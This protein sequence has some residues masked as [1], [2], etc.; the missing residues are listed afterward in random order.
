[1]WPGR[2]S[3]VQSRVWTVGQS[4]GVAFPLRPLILSAWQLG[5]SRSRLPQWPSARPRPHT[6]GTRCMSKLPSHSISLS[7]T[8]KQLIGLFGMYLLRCVTPASGVHLEVYSGNTDFDWLLSGSNVKSRA[9]WCLLKVLQ[10]TLLLS[11]GVLA[12]ALPRTPAPQGCGPGWSPRHGPERLP[13]PERT[14]HR[15]S[16]HHLPKPAARAAFGGFKV[17]M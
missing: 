13:R 8:K 9:P 11:L 6:R 2:Q 14:D 1:M 12:A 15:G 7:L 17:R 4:G 16:L 5:R 10:K 3:R